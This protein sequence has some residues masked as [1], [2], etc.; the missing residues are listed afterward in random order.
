MGDALNITDFKTQSYKATDSIYHLCIEYLQNKQECM[1]QLRC[2]ESKYLFKLMHHD[3]HG[4]NI[5]PEVIQK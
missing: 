1:L 5:K 4:N 2:I 3:G